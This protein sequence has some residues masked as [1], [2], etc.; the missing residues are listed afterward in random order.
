[1]I[2]KVPGRCRARGVQLMLSKVSRTKTLRISILAIGLASTAFSV[3]GKKKKSSEAS[4][5][6]ESKRALHALNRLTFG[7][8]P[9]DVQRVAAM[10]V[11]KWIDQQLHPEKIDDSAV[12]ARLAPFRTL[13]M[14]NRELVE[15]FPPPQVIKAV[16]DGKQKMPSDPAKRAVYE[17]QIQR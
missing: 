2:M 1:F 4:G 17:A 9:G 6:D 14:D 10:G 8:R 13:R 5:Q 12:E 15:N 7:P 16:M 11:D 3:A